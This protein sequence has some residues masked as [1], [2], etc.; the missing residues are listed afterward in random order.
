M[1]S[2][3]QI[4]S[5]LELNLYTFY[6]FLYETRLSTVIFAQVFALIA[7]VDQKRPQKLRFL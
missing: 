3:V 5:Y 7:A 6:Q 4:K 1:I 2:S